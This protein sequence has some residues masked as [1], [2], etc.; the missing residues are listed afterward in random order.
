MAE[1]QGLQLEIDELE[2][3]GAEVLAVA[4]DPVAQNAEV[5]RQLGLD[6]RILSDDRLEAIDAYDLRHDDGGP[7]G[8]I[9]RSA[10]FVIDADG[11]VRWRSL[12]D[13]YRFRPRAEDVLAAVAEVEPI[14]VQRRND[15]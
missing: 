5:V 7:N 14:Q 3:R 8:A 6:Y 10:T 9:A 11:V 12:E 2:G 4:V 15:P 1:L 13:S